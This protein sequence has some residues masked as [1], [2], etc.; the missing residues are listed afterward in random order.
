M[1]RKLCRDVLHDIDQVLVSR[2][3]EIK[4]TVTRCVA[5][6]LHL[7]RH[8][9]PTNVSL[10]TTLGADSLDIVELE[11]QLEQT[12]SISLPH[13]G[14]RD[15]AVCAIGGPFEEGGVVRSERLERLRLL[16]PEVDPSLIDDRLTESELPNL[17]TVMTVVRLIAFH[18]SARH[19][20][21]FE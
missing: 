14:L 4:D 16:L 18:I 20:R 17:F 3:D 11:L 8:Q 2:G 19:E 6:A 13:G 15:L 12:L 9:L 1:M 10:V 7:D 21:T 5:D